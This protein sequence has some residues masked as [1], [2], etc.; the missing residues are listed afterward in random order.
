[1]AKKKEQAKTWMLSSP[2]QRTAKAPLPER[3]KADLDAKAVKL[4][5]RLKARYVKPPP[6]DYQFNYIT[7]VL[8]Q[9][10]RQHPLFRHDLC[11]PRPDSDLAV[12]RVKVCEDGAS[13][14]RSLLPVL[15][16]AHGEVVQAVSEPGR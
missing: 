12:V 4:V 13:W 8:D 3:I 16:V 14:R 10:D 7:D 1:M 5:E 6:N 2:S 9:V 11:L 15:H